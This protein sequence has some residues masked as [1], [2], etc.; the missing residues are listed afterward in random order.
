LFIQSLFSRLQYVV[1]NISLLQNGILKFLHTSAQLSSR[2]NE[3]DC[4]TLLRETNAL[5]KELFSIFGG[6]EQESEKL[7]SDFSSWT[8]LPA[9]NAPSSSPSPPRIPL[10]AASIASTTMQHSSLPITEALTHTDQSGKARMV[11]IGSKPPTVRSAT[12][13]ASVLLGPTAFAL[14]VANQVSKGDVLTVAQ[15]AGVM[16]AKQTSNLIPLCH[17]LLL[18]HVDVTLTLDAEQHAV[19]ISATASTSGSTGVEME[20]MTAASVS[21]LTVYDMCKAA[22]KGIEVA[23]V[24][25]ERKCGGK[26]GLWQRKDDTDSDVFSV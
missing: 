1:N 6:S 25:L 9:M 4:S 5:N 16:G 17:P 13:T 21:A 20:A 7:S 11:D 24:R 14:V 19:K 22:S 10:A 26:S 18:S 15:L 2:V 8:P 12:A 3:E 23:H